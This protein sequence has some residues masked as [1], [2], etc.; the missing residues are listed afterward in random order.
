MVPKSDTYYRNL[1]CLIISCV[2]GTIALYAF[3]C[4]Y[5][6]RAAIAG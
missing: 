6:L 3:A 4:G 2:V 1:G 5:I